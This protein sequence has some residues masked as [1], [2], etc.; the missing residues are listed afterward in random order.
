[1]DIIT[2]TFKVIL[3]DEEEGIIYAC[4][5]KVEPRETHRDPLARTVKH[6]ENS[7]Y[8]YDHKQMKVIIGRILEGHKPGIT[9][10]YPFPSRFSAKRTLELFRDV[11]AEDPFIRDMD[12]KHGKKLKAY[13]QRG[14]ELLHKKLSS[15]TVGAVSKGIQS[16]SVSAPVDSPSLQ[17]GTR[18]ST[19]GF[20]AQP[21]GY[22]NYPSLKPTYQPPAPLPPYPDDDTID[23][24]L[25]EGSAPAPAPGQGQSYFGSNYIRQVPTFAEYV[26][27][28]YQP[29]AYANPPT[30]AT[31]PAT[32]QIGQDPDPPT[33]SSS[34]SGGSGPPPQ[35]RRLANEQS[36]MGAEEHQRYAPT[37]QERA[38]RDDRYTERGHEKAEKHTKDKRGG[39]PGKT[40]KD[41]AKDKED[42]G[43]GRRRSR[44]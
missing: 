11:D 10:K 37:G 43:T 9:D 2:R 40:R 32:V 21:G 18:G 23:P 5:L 29:S 35:R 25:L 3:N 36:R 12:A 41:T 30:Q 24:R 1:M 22:P 28:N 13:L 31:G 16:M 7:K 33:S 26:G 20:Q 14:S 44:R 6:D 39:A 15:G 4:S 17:S 34:P 19:T 38:R 42:T 27:S 8:T